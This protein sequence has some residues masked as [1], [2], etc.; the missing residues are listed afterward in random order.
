VLVAR[1]EEKLRA[2]AT[3]LDTRHGVQVHVIAADLSREGAPQQV[4]DE[5]AQRG[6]AID[7]L[8]NNAG[9]ATYARFGREPF[10]REH[11]QVMLNVAAVVDLTYLLLPA[12]LER[13]HGGIINVASTAGFQPVPYMSVYGATKAF[14]ISFSEALWAENRGTGV[15][16]LALCPGP[17]ETPFFDAVGSREPAVGVM[18]TSEN[19]VLTGLR[20]LEQGKNY[21]IPGWQTYLLAQVARFFPRSWVVLIAK[22]M[23]TPR[24]RAAR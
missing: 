10:A 5:C 11:G 15:R 3:D 4:A 14:V 22:Q 21:V 1:S 2:L 6:L 9:F 19:V 12:M 16:V 17:V 7:L 18:N 24:D 20:A 8:I 13:G 23:F